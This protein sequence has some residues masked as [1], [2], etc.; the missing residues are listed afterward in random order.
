MT[1]NPSS[2]TSDG[3]F[4]DITSLR[5]SGM[6]S[7]ISEPT[8][9]ISDPQ[10]VYQVHPETGSQKLPPGPR[11]YFCTYSC[12][13]KS[14]VKR[15]DWKSHE[16][17]C[18]D[19]QVEF[20]CTLCNIPVSFHLEKRFTQHH[21]NNHG[22]KPCSHAAECKRA[23]PTKRAWGC[24]FCG[25]CLPTWDARAKH[26]ATHFENGMDLSSWEHR[27]VIRGLLRQPTVA[28]EWLEILNRMF[29]TPDCWPQL[30]WLEDDTSDLQNGLQLGNDISAET[31]ASE[32]FRLAIPI[33]PRTESTIEFPRE[34]KI[35]RS[36]AEDPINRLDYIGTA[37]GNEAGVEGD[38]HLQ[39]SLE[40][41]TFNHC[42]V[43]EAQL[44]ATHSVQSP[45]SKDVSNFTE[46]LDIIDGAKESGAF[47]GSYEDFVNLY[48]DC[49]S[50]TLNHDIGLATRDMD[51]LPDAW[52]ADLPIQSH[53]E[54]NGLFHSSIASDRQDM[55]HHPSTD[56]TF[57]T[58]P[59]RSILTNYTNA[60]QPTSP[61]PEAPFLTRPKTP[62]GR[63]V[64]RLKTHT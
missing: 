51:L 12:S 15:S 54:G 29:G 13:Q 4:L 6:L 61:L 62:L 2:T 9:G 24:G 39:E 14:F 55:S 48:M 45:P 52:T 36:Q 40:V 64:K 38:S 41:R 60:T 16:T 32:A 59:P 44:Q 22:C 43:N 46:T 50:N 37:Q 31:L 26:V 27:Q 17:Q 58:S 53:T 57:E 30:D 10:S 63:F 47:N 3:L 35:L 5:N 49:D 8:Q 19:P 23:L 25:Q 42:L 33:E 7:Q 20:I 1:S 28:K 18:H 11:I 56:H 21:G 34:S